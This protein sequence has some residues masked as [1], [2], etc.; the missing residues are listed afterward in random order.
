MSYD[1]EWIESPVGLIPK[2]NHRQLCSKK[3]PKGEASIWVERLQLVK[4]RVVVL[5]LAGG[6]HVSALKNKYPE[7]EIIVFEHIE[8]ISRKIKTNALLYTDIEK[9]LGDLY[10][11]GEGSF[12]V[13]FHP[14]SYALHRELYD[15]YLKVLTG[16]DIQYRDQILGLLGMKG[17]L[18]P[19]VELSIDRDFHKNLSLE[20][21]KQKTDFYYISKMTAEI[22]K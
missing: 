11:N 3:D 18:N 5:G 17:S 10:L 9:L 6:Y 14:A 2:V 19:G 1:V 21:E 20:T 13:V 16:R 4:A 8:E 7:K 12:Q 15:Q 22:L